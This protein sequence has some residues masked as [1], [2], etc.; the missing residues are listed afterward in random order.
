MVMQGSELAE[1]RERADMRAALRDPTMLAERETLELA[2][3]DG[4]ACW[5]ERLVWLSGRES[6]DC[7]SRTT[8][9]LL[10]SEDSQTSAM[11]EIRVTTRFSNYHEFEG[12]VVPTTLIQ[13]S[14]GQT[15]EMAV[16]EVRIGDVTAAEL[17]PPPSIRTLLGGPGNP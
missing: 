13:T 17:E 7:Y 15:Q 8:G 5:R 9:L 14:M 4:E 12:M 2:E 1:A 16:E 3:I 6:V 11:G 10:A